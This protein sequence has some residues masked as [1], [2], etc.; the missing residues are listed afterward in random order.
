MAQVTNPSI[1]SHISAANDSVA[2]DS[3]SKPLKAIELI[4]TSTE[5]P[6]NEPTQG[7]DHQTSW[8]FLTIIVLFCIIALRFHNNL[9][10]VKALLN[11]LIEVRTRHNMF[12][13]TVRETIFLV[14]LNILYFI[15]GGVLLFS[16]IKLMI[17]TTPYGSISVGCGV[18]VGT[19]IC[20]LTIAVYTLCM[21]VAYFAVGNVF[22]NMEQTRLWLKGYAASQAICSLPLLP[23][24]L[25]ALCYPNSS[26]IILILAGISYILSK[27][28]FLWKGFRIF[29]TQISSW[30]LFLYYL[31]SLEIIPLLLTFFASMAICTSVS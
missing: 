13:D 16:L 2:V 8:I 24:A 10:Y 18:G 17:P 31:C 23:L 28:V 25:L 27:C 6:Q 1:D 26:S 30:I 21:L 20:T 14:L 12:D 15:S 22:S 3:M 11:D 7:A 9:R 29:F 19:L 5:R 4:D